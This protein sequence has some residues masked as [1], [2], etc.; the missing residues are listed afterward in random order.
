VLGQLSTVPVAG[1]RLQVSYNGH[2]LYTFT[3][4]SPGHAT[5]DGLFDLFDGVGFA[6]HVATITGDTLA[7]A[8][9]GQTPSGFP[10]LGATPTP[11]TTLT[12]SPTPSPS[13][14]AGQ[15]GA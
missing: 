2:L 11:S 6:W 8:A 13:A 7:P 12:P 4:D 1:G 15:V 9:P 5:G 10:S 3:V 14:S